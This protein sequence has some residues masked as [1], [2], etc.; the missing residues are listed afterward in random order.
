[1][2]DVTGQQ[3][4]LDGLGVVAGDH[5]IRAA[6]LAGEHRARGVV[7]DE[8]GVGHDEDERAGERVRHADRGDVPLRE[9]AVAGLAGVQ[10]VVQVLRRDIDDARLAVRLVADDRHLPAQEGAGIDAHVAQHHG[11][12]AGGDLLAGG[13]HG[14]GTL[15][16]LDGELAIV[17]G[18]PWQI[19]WHGVAHLVPLETRT[20]F[21]VVSTLA[22]TVGGS[23]VQYYLRNEDAEKLAS[24]VTTAKGKTFREIFMSQVKYDASRLHFVGRVAYPDFISLLQ[25]SMAHVYLSYPFVLSWSLLEAMSLGTPVITSTASC[26]PEIAGVTQQPFELAVDD[27]VLRAPI[28]GVVSQRLAQPGERV[29]LDEGPGVGCGRTRQRALALS[30]SLRGRQ[31]RDDQRKRRA[32]SGRGSKAARSNPDCTGRSARTKPIRSCSGSPRSSM[33]P[34]WKI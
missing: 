32:Q 8:D 11:Q 27:A 25:V 31:Q 34:R 6:E 18:E 30:R 4:A 3:P 24:G 26:L 13:D 28:G 12:Q 14:L 29:A 19:D 1:M 23:I 15:D 2:V 9:Q 33:S 20:P 22:F 17:D 21:V 5:A 10:R 16:H 7:E